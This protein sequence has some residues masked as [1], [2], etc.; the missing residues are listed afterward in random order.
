M[1]L[2]EICL[3]LCFCICTCTET[4]DKQKVKLGRKSC[5][6]SFSFTLDS[7]LVVLA[8]SSVVCN[9]KCSGSSKKLKLTHQTSGRV[10]TLGLKVKRGKG[11][12]SKAAFEVSG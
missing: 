5:L 9:K 4:F 3:F 12:L 8:S 6:C 1:R 2:S 11:S 10:Y 7:D